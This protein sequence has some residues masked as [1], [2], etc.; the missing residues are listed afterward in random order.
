M[1]ASEL[2]ITEHSASEQAQALECE[3]EFRVDPVEAE[4]G[5]EL[6]DNEAICTVKWFVPDL[7]KASSAELP[8]HEPALA[9]ADAT[10]PSRAKEPEADAKVDTGEETT[11]IAG[12]ASGAP[13]T[14]NYVSGQTAHTRGAATK[15]KAPLG[16]IGGSAERQPAAIR[17][18]PK[19]SRTSNRAAAE[20]ANAVGGNEGEQEIYPPDHP[21][22][23]TRAYLDTKRIEAHWDG[24]FSTA[25][26]L[27][28]ATHYG[29]VPA[30][31][32]VKEL[33]F[34]AVVDDM[35][36]HYKA[37]GI[38]L[39]KAD[40]K[41]ALRKEVERIHRAR[42]AEII[43]PL[44]API[45]KAK[46]ARANREWWQLADIIELDKIL[47][48]AILKHYVWQ[49]KQKALRR[50]VVHHLMPIIISAQG[51]GKTKFSE[52]FHEPLDELASD[53]VLLSDFVDHR[54]GD[55][56]RYL[57][58]VIDDVGPLAP[59]QVSTLKS[60]LTSDYIQRRM[61]GTSNT[62]K[63]RQRATLFGTANDDIR[64]LVADKTGHRR[65]AMLPFRNGALA[66]GGDPAVWKTVTSIDYE[67]LWR[68]VD[69]FRPSPILNHLDKLTRHQEASRPDELR[70]WLIR[71]DVQSEDVRRIQTRL[72]IR[73]K[74]LW[75][76]FV[77]QTG[78][79]MSMTSFGVEM[80]RHASDPLVPFGPKKPGAEGNFY[81]LKG[82][83][84]A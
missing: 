8:E 15:R 5:L 72:G 28:T 79:A 1:P 14:K 68:S 82:R 71:L 27:R 4:P 32:A 81:P 64:D 77:A 26:E 21:I 63:Y 53:P 36:L 67:L 37:L 40:A 69:A 30:F 34:K 2:N 45:G 83:S 3:T 23:L 16:Q 55:I 22:S 51:A 10:F 66:R 80:N 12:A 50:K 74:G 60:L 46:R 65:F 73:A 25:N 41:R 61:L 56:Y 44:V 59:K 33:D 29:E 57:A 20:I 75:E 18:M 58:V 11:A 6:R 62:A 31:L 84:P 38:R 54:S 24:S 35:L 13:G 7:P 48:T 78:S 19:C 47:T 76:L 49:V 9:A 39:A 17:T 42:F 52:K 43:Q 70:S